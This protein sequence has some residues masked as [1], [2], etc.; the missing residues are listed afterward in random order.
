MSK[1]KKKIPLTTK[2]LRFRLAELY[3]DVENGDIEAGKAKVMVGAASAYIKS[4]GTDILHMQITGDVR[5]MDEFENGYDKI[6]I[7]RGKG[8]NDLPD[9]T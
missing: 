1:A 9:K 4:L 6:E 7:P 2:E 3:N 5:K 8:G